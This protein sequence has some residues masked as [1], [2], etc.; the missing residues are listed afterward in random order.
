MLLIGIVGCSDNKDQKDGKETNKEQTVNNNNENKDTDKSKDSENYQI[1]DYLG[2]TY[3]E[4]TYGYFINVPRFAGTREGGASLVFVDTSMFIATGIVDSEYA[5]IFKIDL[6]SIVKTED[7]APG[8]KNGMI[9]AATNTLEFDIA[10][11]NFESSKVMEVNGREVC[12]FTGYLKLEEQYEG[13]KNYFVAGYTTFYN[14][15]PMYI[16]AVNSHYIQNDETS[17][18]VNQY[19]DDIIK[20]LRDKK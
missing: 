8:I 11:I 3:E 13:N 5:N 19:V 12:R 4:P 9:A 10:D 14:D 1:P 15:M 6:N 7:I 2:L 20:T 18:K 17:K 16:M